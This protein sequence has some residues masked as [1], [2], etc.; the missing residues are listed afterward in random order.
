VTSDPDQRLSDQEFV[1][2]EFLNPRLASTA[3]TY[4]AALT[5]LWIGNG[6]AALATLSFV[7][8]AWHNGEPMRALLW[9]LWCFVL[10]LISM[11]VGSGVSIYRDAQS[12]RR[13]QQAQTVL[14]LSVGDIRSPAEEAGLS[15]GN[16]RTLSAIAAAVLFV[17]GCLSGLLLLT[18][19]CS[20]G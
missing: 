17:A 8:A 2:K 14:E 3:K 19:R 11:G 10:G 20:L 16:F 1:V 9:P 13:L 18:F 12:I 7:G 15:F 5:S 6:A 4:T